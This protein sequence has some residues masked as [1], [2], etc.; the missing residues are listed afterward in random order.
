MFLWEPIGSQTALK[1]HSNILIVQI[2]PH[3]SK[4]LTQPVG[5][6]QFTFRH[7]KGKHWVESRQNFQ[8]PPVLPSHYRSPHVKIQSALFPRS[9][10]L[11]K[12]L[13][14]RQA[15]SILLLEKLVWIQPKLS[16]L[17]PLYE[18]DWREQCIY[19]C[20]ICVFCLFLL[21][22]PRPDAHIVNIQVNSQSLLCDN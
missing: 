2:I 12:S 8:F 13:R 4:A 21:W 14:G 5:W 6:H 9:S 10:I 11:S 17:S 18:T 19:K 3:I 1:Q 22:H 16:K 7:V 15:S 20:I